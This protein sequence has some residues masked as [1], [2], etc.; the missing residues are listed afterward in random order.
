MSNEETYVLNDSSDNDAD[1]D[2]ETIMYH[3]E[4]V[5]TSKRRRKS[6]ETDTESRKRR[7]KGASKKEYS[8]EALENAVEDIRTGNTLL[9]TSIKHK[10]PRSTLYM[11]VKALGIHLNPSRSDYTND[12]IR[13]AIDLVI[14]TLIFNIYTQKFFRLIISFG[15]FSW[16]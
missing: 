5:P 1:G 6:S 14:G 12:D 13:Q 10:I 8:D 15:P 11:R 4:S 16:I 3:E 2:V 7:R 9:G